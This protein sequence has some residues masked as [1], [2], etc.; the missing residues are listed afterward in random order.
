MAPILGYWDIRGLATPIRLLLVQAGV[1]YE[2]KFYTA[3]GPPDFDR[4]HWTNE[5]FNLGLEFPNLPYYIDGETKLTQ[6][7]VILRYLANKYNLAGD[8]ETERTRADLLATQLAD[9][10]MDYVM[11]CYNPN[12]LNLKDA[13]AEGVPGKMNLLAKFLGSNKF[14]VGD[15]LTYADFVLFEYL[16]NQLY[17]NPQVLNDFPSLDQY[18][19]RMQSVE[20]VDK[21][22]KSSKAIK[23]PFNN[24]KAAFGGRLSEQP[25]KK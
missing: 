4:S 24:S 12:F 6:S 25:S 5:K 22:F 3:G 11:I 2:E 16:E 23:Y 19:K 10:H 7:G 17:F 9:Y 20:A 13:Y 21:Y 14:A 8:N 1:E 18:H 15:K